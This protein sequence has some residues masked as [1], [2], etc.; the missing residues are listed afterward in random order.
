VIQAGNRDRRV[1]GDVH[2]RLPNTI[3][4]LKPPETPHLFPNSGH[5]IPDRVDAVL[6]HPEGVLQGVFGASV[7]P[8]LPGQE[9]VQLFADWSVGITMRFPWLP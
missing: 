7:V 1:A 5:L 6:G 9:G 8:P 4:R 3:V 2:E